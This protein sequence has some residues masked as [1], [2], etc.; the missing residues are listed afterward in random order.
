MEGWGCSE[1]WKGGLGKGCSRRKSL[2]SL[3]PPS[4]GQWLCEVERFDPQTNEWSLIA[5]MHH[6]RTGVAVTALRGTVGDV[7]MCM[8]MCCMERFTK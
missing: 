8:Y 4:S 7:Y 1:C 2:N 3:F 5:P 6:S